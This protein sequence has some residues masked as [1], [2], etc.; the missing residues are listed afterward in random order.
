MRHPVWVASRH[1][2]EALALAKARTCEEVPLERVLF[3]SPSIPKSMALGTFLYVGNIDIQSATGAS[4]RLRSA[5]AA[6]HM[7]HW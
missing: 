2:R 3:C 5:Y 4:K 7:R 1:C 6:G